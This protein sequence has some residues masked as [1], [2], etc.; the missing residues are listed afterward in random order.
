MW[1]NNYI[2]SDDWKALWISLHCLTYENEVYPARGLPCIDK[3]QKVIFTQD[4]FADRPTSMDPI[5]SFICG[6]GSKSYHK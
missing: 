3:L 6:D 5:G 2:C 4:F 1:P